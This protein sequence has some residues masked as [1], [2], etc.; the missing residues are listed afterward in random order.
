[1][2]KLIKLN[3]YLRNTV[4]EVRMQ[5]GYTQLQLGKLA[6]VAGPTISN[7][8]SGKQRYAKKSVIQAL[9]KALDDP[10]LVDILHRKRRGF[11]RRIPQETRERVQLDPIPRDIPDDHSTPPSPAPK[12]GI[13][14]FISN[15]FIRGFIVGMVTASILLYATL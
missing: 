3:S 14:I 5:K 4:K 9:S 13:T 1:M 11:S 15:S 8:E 7:I 10:D 6:G 12:E 2:R